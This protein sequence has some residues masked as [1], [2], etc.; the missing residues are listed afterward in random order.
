LTQKEIEDAG[1][2]DRAKLFADIAGALV[3]INDEDLPD[4]AETTSTLFA[5]D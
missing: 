2:F 4:R 1:L 5:D 3:A